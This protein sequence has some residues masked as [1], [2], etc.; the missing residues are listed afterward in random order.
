M[1]FTVYITLL[2]SLIVS[3]FVSIRI[4]NKKEN[5]WLA[6]LVGFCM[7]TFLLVALTIIFYKVYH[8]KEIEGLFASLGIFVFAFFIPILTCINFYIL[9]YVRSKVK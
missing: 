8:V 3:S 7:N 2:I 4:F 6:V 1:N 9:E 5:K